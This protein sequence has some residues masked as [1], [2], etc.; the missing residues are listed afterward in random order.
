MENP[1]KTPLFRAE[2]VASATSVTTVDDAL[3]VVPPPLK[4]LWGVLGAL[5]VGLLGW[6]AVT[7]VPVKINGQG[8]LL[9][10]GGLTD[11]VSDTEGR[12]VE[13]TARP[14]DLVT[15]GSVVAVVDQAEL[16]LQ[17]AAAE[18]ELRD[19]ETARSEMRRFQDREQAADRAWRAARDEGLARS[20]RAAQDR[21]RL[22]TERE[23]VVR[24]LADRSL[25][26]RDR[27]IG[28]Q[29]ELFGVRDQIESLQ[30]DRRV[31]EMDAMMRQT[32]RERDLLT[33]DQRVQ[34][35]ERQV[36]TLTERIQ[37]MGAVRSPFDGRVV[38]AKANVGQVVNRGG[39]LLTLVRSDSDAGSGPLVG[40]VYVGAQD[41]K[42]LQPGMVVDLSPAT[43]P[44]QEYGYLRGRVLRVAD[45]P[46]SSAGMLRTL[47]NDA[48]V[49]EFQRNQRTLFE[50]NIELEHDARGRHVWSGGNGPAFSIEGGTPATMQATV[51]QVRM[52]A[53]GLPAL[54]RWLGEDVRV[55]TDAA[56]P[57]A[58]T[59]SQLAR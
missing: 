13:F 49:S 27:A 25:A 24:D 11:I 52:I 23:G 47:Q 33:A 15:A 6:S 31:L 12:V 40:L 21:L 54:Q 30:N 22:L 26:T 32:Q 50:V 16:R 57:R 39:P 45:T 42:K 1:G 5:T 7:N 59:T 41:G 35:A 29:I 36:T 53:L 9:S 17:L 18:G 38:E 20:L 37:R 43:A 8:I 10:A 55:T 28:A 48:L 58:V 2:A 56:A 14:G 44:S 19:A 4:I 34:T 51:R 46:A 3:E